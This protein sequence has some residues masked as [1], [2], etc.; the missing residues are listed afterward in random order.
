MNLLVS[1]SSWMLA[2]VVY[3]L[4]LGMLA[5]TWSAMDPASLRAAFDADGKSLW[6]RI[7]TLK[8]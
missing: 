4:A 6:K 5:V 7:V 2:P 8:R 1:K 3:L